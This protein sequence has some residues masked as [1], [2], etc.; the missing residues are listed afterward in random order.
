LFGTDGVRGLANVEPITPACC[1][2][3]AQSAAQILVEPSL[4]RPKVVLG[5]DTRASGEMLEAA[6][7][8]G[9]ASAGIDVLLTGIVPTPAVSYLTRKHAADFGIVIS[10]SHNPFEDNGIKFFAA[11]GYKLTDA[12]ELAIEERYW[13]PVT[14]N[15]T[16][17]SVGRIRALEYPTESYGAY[18]AATFPEQFDLK[19]I[20]IAVDAANGAGYRTT[21]LVLAELGADVQLF[22]A[23]PDGWNINLDCGSTHPETLVELT[24]SSGAQLGLAHDGDADRLLFCDENAVPLD[25][26]ELLAIAA[27]FFLERGELAKQTV[28]ATIMSNFGLERAVAQRGGKVIRSNVGDR[29]VIEAMIEHDL[30]L[31]GE[32]SGHLVFGNYATTGDGLVSALQILRIMIFTGKPLSELRKILVKVPQAQRNIA[33]R[34]KVP[35]D[36]LP[37]LQEKL[38]IARAILNGEGRVLLRYSGTESKARLLLEGP[39]AGQLEIIADDLAGEIEAL[40]G[41]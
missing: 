41:R 12:Q 30:N 29:F 4:N 36:K 13:H 14:P 22:N 9:L 15:R 21:P 19:G 6:V 39:D 18:A 11:T 24:K 34:E 2:R 31:G 5:R 25:G 35:F 10:G 17:Q 16:G 33:V 1:V 20:R 38:R 3:I 40:L 32:Q 8:A 23:E 26:D 7:A 37:S 28:A 27:A